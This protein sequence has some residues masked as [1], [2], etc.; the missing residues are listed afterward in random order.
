MMSGMESTS[1]VYNSSLVR[2][3]SSL[4][5]LGDLLLEH[6]IDN[7]ILLRLVFQLPVDLVD[8]ARSVSIAGSGNSSAGRVFQGITGNHSDDVRTIKK[9][10]LFSRTTKGVGLIRWRRFHTESPHPAGKV[11]QRNGMRTRCRSTLKRSSS[12]A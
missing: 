2:R 9:K 12:P 11:A 7:P 5:A 1:F 4:A 6:L 8:F 10:L 3:A